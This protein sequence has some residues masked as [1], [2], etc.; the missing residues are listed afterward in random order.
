L[1][2]PIESITRSRVNKLKYAFN[3]LI[4]DIKASV[5]FKEATSANKN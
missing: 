1:Q 2:V 4:H 3:D 5:D